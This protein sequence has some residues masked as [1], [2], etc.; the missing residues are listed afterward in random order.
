[1]SELFDQETD[2]LDYKDMVG[3]W[4]EKLLEE[5]GQ[6][7]NTAVLDSL[8]HPVGRMTWDRWVDGLVAEVDEAEAAEAGAAA[9]E[10]RAEPQRR[11]ARGKRAPLPHKTAEVKS[12]VRWRVPW[13]SRRRSRSARPQRRSARSR[14]RSQALRPARARISA[15]G[16]ACGRASTTC[17]GRGPTAATTAPATRGSRQCLIC[18]SARLAKAR[19]LQGRSHVLSS[20]KKFR[21]VYEGKSHIYNSALLR[22]PD[23]CREEL[24]EKAA[25]DALARAR[26]SGRSAGRS[27]RPSAS[28]TQS[29]R[30]PELPKPQGPRRWPHGSESGAR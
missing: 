17:S 12:E 19:Q 29:R 9:A 8:K 18:D 26:R 13:Q 21:A 3:G 28:E 5:E 27:R 2:I 4:M 1:M 20:L 25:A 22:L 10:E 15:L 14:R 6:S 30:P 16:A 23:A 11:R 24:H 7:P